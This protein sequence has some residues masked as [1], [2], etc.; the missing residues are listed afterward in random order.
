MTTIATTDVLGRPMG[1]RRVLLLAALTIGVGLA[2]ISG[3]AS[4]DD[5]KVSESLK[6]LQGTWVSAE[7]SGFDSTWTFSGDD[8]KSS[9][10]GNEY[11]SKV[12]ADHKAK[13]HPT[14][15]IDIKDGPDE[16]KGKTCKCIYKLD[17]D[18]LVLCLAL[19]DRERPKEFEQVDDEAYVF[20]LKKEK[21]K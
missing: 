14:V 2:G 10:N 21:K 7:D 11:I 17:G 6:A 15:D 20:E 4:A 13:P 16:S 18:K 3:P 5:K 8:L 12:T 1:G 19:P 9:V